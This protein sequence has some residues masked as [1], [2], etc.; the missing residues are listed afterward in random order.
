MGEAAYTR[1]K[2]NTHTHNHNNINTWKSIR[3][4]REST[5]TTKNATKLGLYSSALL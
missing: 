2:K 4:M 3:K 5:T 1:R